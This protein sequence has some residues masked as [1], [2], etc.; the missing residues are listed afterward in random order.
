MSSSCNE[1]H[2]WYSKDRDGTPDTSRCR[3]SDVIDFV[4]Y[5]DSLVADG[6]TPLT[7][8]GMGF[9]YDIIAEESNLWDQCK[10]Q[11]LLH[12][13]MMFHVIC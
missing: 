10:Q 3:D 9:D 12:V 4:H 1:P 13:D 2:I 11:A 7:W 6:F 8:N 5:V